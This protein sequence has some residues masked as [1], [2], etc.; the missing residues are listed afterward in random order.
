MVSSLDVSS[1]QALAWSNL[2]NFSNLK[3]NQTPSLRYSD[4]LSDPTSLRQ[5]ICSYCYG[6]DRDTEKVL[7]VLTES[8]KVISD[9]LETGGTI[10]PQRFT[11]IKGA[12]SNFDQKAKELGSS[13][14]NKKFVDRYNQLFTEFQERANR[15]V[16][17]TIY[18]RRDK[19]K[20]E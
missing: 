4:W 3:E 9:Y 18:A 13:S 2:E 8:V 19:E 16:D 7:D 14:E 12:I 17:F 5:W 10:Y 1:K 6:Y 11:I 20:A 15:N